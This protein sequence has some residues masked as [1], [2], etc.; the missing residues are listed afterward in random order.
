MRLGSNGRRI[1]NRMAPCKV[2]NIGGLIHTADSLLV[3]Y[4]IHHDRYVLSP[5]LV[6]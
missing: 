4:I 3:I 5:I 2:C 1:G 6:S